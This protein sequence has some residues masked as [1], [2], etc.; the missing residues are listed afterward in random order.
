MP[1]KRPVDEMIDDDEPVGLRLPASERDVMVTSRHVPDSMQN[2]IRNAPAR[3]AVPFT[4][5]ELEDLHRGLTFDADQTDDKK[6][7]QAVRK[8]LRKIEEIL[9]EDDGFDEYERGLEDCDEE[10]HL[11]AIALEVLKGLFGSPSSE[12]EEAPPPCQV[13]LTATQRETLRRMETV[14]VDIHKMLD[15][16]SAD[17]LE[18]SFTLRQV[19]VIGM[20]IWESL[21]LS[22]D[23]DPAQPLW[24]IAQQIGG[25]LLATIEGATDEEAD[26]RHQQSKGT[27]AAVAYQLK[28]TLE[29]S[30]PAIWRRVLVADCTLDVLHQIIQTAMGWTDSHLHMFDYNGVQFSDPRCELDEGVYDETQTYLS[31]LVA[32]GCA[33][34]RYCYDFGDNWLHTIKIEKTLEPKPSDRF[35]VCIKG[36]GACPP[37]DCGGIWGYGEFLDAAR[38]PN[39][40]R[41]DESIE[42]LGEDF[43]PAYFD[44]DEVN[45]V[46]AQ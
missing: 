38:D 26:K 3:E 41:H 34:L 35:P 45:A 43:D 39:H 28:I 46:L 40:E 8:V 25:C 4:I 5:E 1:R 15:V 16:E 13:I 27:A 11:P 18:F 2:R 12:R 31:E 24:E 44:L 37:D 29:G 36:V 23:R 22:G 10:P 14:S 32:D 9:E 6:R 20:A 21:V 30:K 17:E 19:L 33:K 7:I 42:W